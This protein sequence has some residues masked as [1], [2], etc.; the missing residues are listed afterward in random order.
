V[1]PNSGAEFT[2]AVKHN[3]TKVESFYKTRHAI[4]QQ[5]VNALHDHYG[6]TER[7]AFDSANRLELEDLIAAFI[8]LRD[9]LKQ[10]QWYELV[11]L[12]KIVGRLAKFEGRVAWSPG[13]NGLR[14]PDTYL[15]I[16]T[17]CLKTLRYVNDVLARLQSKRAE[18]VLA[19]PSLSLLQQKYY[20]ELLASLPLISA[21]SAINLD[22]ASILDQM[23][24]Q[25]VKDQKPIDVINN[26]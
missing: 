13:S 18:L 2:A 5:R 19:Q 24:E 20:D 3:L 21:S 10:L 23:F 14:I 16:R 25:C 1:K 9:I 15:A 4:I 17:E 12:D 22:D 8:E 6:V 11:N 7:T 26:D